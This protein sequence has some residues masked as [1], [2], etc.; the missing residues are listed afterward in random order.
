MVSYV[1]RSTRKRTTTNNR[2]TIYKKRTALPA[3][4][5]GG[6]RKVYRKRRTVGKTLNLLG[7]TKLRPLDTLSEIAPVPIQIGAQA[8]MCA[9]NIGAAPIF[10][11][12][13]PLNGIQVSQGVA[14]NERIGNYLYYKKSHVTLRLEMT[15]KSNAPPIQFRMIMFKPRR[16]VNP[17]G[18][19]PSWSTDGFLNTDGESFGHATL[20]TT[21]LDLMMQPLNKRDWVVYK[22]TKFI[23]QNYNNLE[24]PASTPQLIY[25][26]YPAQK[27]S[28]LNCPYY[29]KSYFPS[30]AISPT[31]LNFSY[32]IVYYA[33]TLGRSGILPN[34]FE[35]TTR[36][37]TSFCDP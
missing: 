18:I 25:N 22:D 1:R 33:H 16:A 32:G 5:Y 14:F 36:G 7:E 12:S 9:F 26:H 30:G 27:E 10:T 20:G 19:T 2:K 3:R 28:Q 37:T 11:S 17:S 15:A 29:K 6:A 8:Y 23:L 24:D 21:G 13:N 35:V 31:D 4:Y 34:G